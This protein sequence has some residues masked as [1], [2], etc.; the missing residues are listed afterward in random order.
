MNKYKIVAHLISPNLQD[1]KTLTNDYIIDY[2][3]YKLGNDNQEFLEKYPIDS[4]VYEEFDSDEEY[5]LEED[6]DGIYLFEKVK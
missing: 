1:E 6:E 5:L 3:I 2:F 4:N